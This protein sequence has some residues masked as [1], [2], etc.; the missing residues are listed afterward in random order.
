MNL[1]RWKQPPPAP[2][3]DR[4]SLK[5]DEELQRKQDDEES[6]KSGSINGK[7]SHKHQY[8]L[9]SEEGKQATVFCFKLLL[10]L[11][12]MVG[13]QKTAVLLFNFVLFKNI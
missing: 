10:P 8:F 4:R 11:P 2:A 7:D 1:D 9:S 13:S 3:R 12:P 6:R 5:D